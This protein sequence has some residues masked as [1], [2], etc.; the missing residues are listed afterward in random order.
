MIVIGIIVNGGGM[1]GSWEQS[2]LIVRTCSTAAGG[3]AKQTHAA[4]AEVMVSVGAAPQE[5]ERKV[6]LKSLKHDLGGRSVKP[7]QR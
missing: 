5:I 7:E 3:W 6:A 4:R 1:N 2:R